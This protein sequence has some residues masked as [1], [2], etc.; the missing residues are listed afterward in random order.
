[1]LEYE[2]SDIIEH[3]NTFYNDV[4]LELRKYGHLLQ[5]LVCSNC[6]PHLRGNVY[7]QYSR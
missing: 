3:F 2:E 7:I 6:E 1:M 4:I 5:F